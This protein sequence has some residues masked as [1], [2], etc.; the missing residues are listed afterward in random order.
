MQSAKLA[1]AA[2]FLTVAAAQSTLAADPSVAGLWQKIDEPTSKSVGWFLFTENDGTYQ[3][4]IAKLFLRPGDPPNQT[5]AACRD[6]RKDQPL[7]GLQLIRDMKPN[8]L[9][10][11]G[12]NILDPRDGNIYNAMMTLSPD[13]QTLT[14]RGYLGIA[15]FGRDE[16]WYR[17]PE[18]AYKDLDPIIV[19]RYLPGMMTASIK[20]KPS[21]TTAKSSNI[22]R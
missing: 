13:G 4:M 14:V 8:G 17:L 9:Y 2:L 3:G 18:T 12:G 19:A 11:E 7:L 10:Y 5:C 15:L 22:A 16:V 21:Q 6:D 20:R 1:M